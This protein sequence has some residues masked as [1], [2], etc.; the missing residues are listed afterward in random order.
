MKAYLSI[1]GNLGDHKKNL[2]EVS[3]RLSEHP[4][5]KL[6]KQ[7]S[8]YETEPWG[9]LDQP[10]F[11]NQVLEIE[12]DLA[13]LELLGICQQIE[14]DLGRKRIIHWGPRTVDID[15]LSYDN[16]VWNDE[17]LTI[18]HPR[19]EEREF[20]LAPLRE[21]APQFILPSGHQVQDVKGH[22]EVY[23]LKNI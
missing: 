5:I 19:M 4:Q 20:V 1:G 12:T 23:L 7:S 2:L 9:K 17:R 13:P 16:R 22:G 3:R 10:N 6:K 18:P 8:I 15:I 21:I 11:W 14:N